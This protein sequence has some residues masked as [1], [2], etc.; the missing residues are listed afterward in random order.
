MG[1][2]FCHYNVTVYNLEDQSISRSIRYPL[3]HLSTLF[4]VIGY[5]LF[6]LELYFFR[7][8]YARTT[9][10]AWIFFC[11][12]TCILCFENYPRLVAGVR[13]LLAWFMQLTLS[14]KILLIFIG[15]GLGV[16]FFSAI[17]ASLLP[18]HLVQEGDVLNYHI[19]LPRQHL[20]RGSFNHISWSTADLFL[21]PID[22][23]LTPFW[24]ATSLPNKIPQFFFL[25]GLLAV[26]GRLTWRL[27]KGQVWPVILLIIAVIGTH[28]VGIQAGTGMLD[29]LICYL[30]LAAIDSF[31]SRRFM[32]GAVELCFYLWSKPFMSV[33]SVVIFG[34]CALIC[35]ILWK[36]K[37]INEIV[38]T[39]GKK[40]KEFT[41]W[42]R[43]VFIRMMGVF[44]ILSLCVAGPFIAKSL[45]YSG[46]PL[47]PVSVGTFKSFSISKSPAY[48]SELEQKGENLLATRNQ[49]G[50]G[51]NILEFMRHFWLAAVPEEGVN[52]RYDYPLG[53]MYLLFFGPFVFFFLSSLCRRVLP[54]L[55]LWVIVSWVVWW[56]GIQQTRFLLVPLIL[57]YLAVALSIGRP[58]RIML[59]SM[60][61]AV[62]LVSVSV[63]R[64]HN[65]DFGRWGYNVLRAKDKDLI[66]LGRGSPPASLSFFDLAYATFIVDRVDS[67]N[68]VFVLKTVF[69]QDEKLQEE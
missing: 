67:N 51:W 29:I 53:L 63:Y 68:P 31:L 52:N 15:I 25:I 13:K 16:T 48:W 11:F 27:S 66:Q 30:F 24:L 60:L 45:R 22:F 40:I 5:P 49:Y 56:W 35:F 23:A 46:T 28:S 34:V 50:S 6:W 69:N 8:G 54:L 42:N 44:F 43:P 61:A 59:G 39:P 32:I 33:Q 9:P 3:S 41:N 55:S 58:S 10:L 62:L 36:L 19:T 7:S 26:C 1:C 18:P 17:Y 2:L 12:F 20:L 57:M 14:V 64:T 21:L 38:I 65:Q 4:L 47:F 37:V